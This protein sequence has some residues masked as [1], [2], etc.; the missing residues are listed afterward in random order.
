MPVL[1]P[2]SEEIVD[3]R[4]E[5][6]SR[7]TK[8]TADGFRRACRMYLQQHGKTKTS[9]NLIQDKLSEPVKTSWWVSLARGSDSL[10]LAAHHG[11]YTAQAALA[12]GVL[13]SYRFTRCRCC[14][15]AGAD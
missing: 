15:V 14:L 6:E 8:D 13:D 7:L 2:K 12:A 4:Q 5:N 9:V 1:E 3:A 11:A 10:Q